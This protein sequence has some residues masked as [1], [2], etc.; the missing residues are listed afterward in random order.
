M[1][2]RSAGFGSAFPFA[3]DT[4]EDEKEWLFRLE[5]AVKANMGDP[6]FGIDSLASMMGM[7]RTNFYRRVRLTTGL[8]ANEF[9]RDIRLQTARELLESGQ[10]GNVKAVCERV[11]MRTSRYFSRLYRE[12]FG[13]SPACGG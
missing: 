1:K 2:E 4:G 9:I 13:K 8:S 5:Q 12:R 11:G 10:A 7:R 6:Q 3:A